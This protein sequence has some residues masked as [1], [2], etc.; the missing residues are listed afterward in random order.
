MPSRKIPF[1]PAGASAKAAIP[2]HPTRVIYA[3]NVRQTMRLPAKSQRYGR[4]RGH[5]GIRGEGDGVVWRGRG[6]GEQ[7]RRAAG[8]AAVRSGINFVCF[9]DGV[10]VWRSGQDWCDS[11][12]DFQVTGTT[13]KSDGEAVSDEPIFFASVCEPRFHAQKRFSGGKTLVPGE[14]LPRGQIQNRSP[15]KRKLLWDK[16]AGQ[17]FG[18]PKF[19]MPQGV[20][21]RWPA[22]T[23]IKK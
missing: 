7:A 23:G 20:T 13:A 14:F 10:T 16:V 4:I 21:E 2:P 15:Q 18:A 1:R 3:H 8:S 9:E 5:S 17:S 22:I 6:R 11:R 19:R 12:Y